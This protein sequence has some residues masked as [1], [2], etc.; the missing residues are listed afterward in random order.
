MT[1]NSFGNVGFW[2]PRSTRPSASMDEGGV[3]LEEI[4]RLQG[5]V[6]AYKGRYNDFRSLFANNATVTEIMMKNNCLDEIFTRCSLAVESLLHILVDVEEKERVARSYQS[7]LDVRCLFHEEFAGRIR[8]IEPTPT[9]TPLESPRV[10][11]PNTS[12]NSTYPCS[13][14]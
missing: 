3:R 10:T 2:R 4:S 1:S 13:F 12:G 5:T 7:E 8:S 11:R 9:P 14:D 6:S